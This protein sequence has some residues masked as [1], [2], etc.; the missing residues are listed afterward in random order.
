MKYSRFIAARY[1]TAERRHGQSASNKSEDRAEHRFVSTIVLIAA[2]GVALGVAALVVTLSILSGFEKTL[3]NNVLG[4]TSDVEISS[5]GNRPLPDFPGTTRFLTQRVPE[6]RSMVPFVEREAI[7]RS[8]HGVAGII[9]RGLPLSDTAALVRHR[10]VRGHDFASTTPDSLPPILISIGLAS[11]LHIDTGKTLAAIRMNERLRSR[12][13]ILANLRKFRVV[14]IY[15]TGMTQYDNSVAFT[16]LPAA[17]AFNGLSMT[18]VTGYDIRT[19]SI[20][21]ANPVTRKINRVLRYPYFARSVYDVYPTIFAWIDLQKKPIPIILGLIILVATFNVVS[22]LLLIVI[23]KTHSIGVLKTLGATMGGIAR[24][25]VTEG[26]TIAIFGTLIGDLI[27]FV[28]CT[29]EAHY[30]FFKLRAEIYFMSS[31]PVSIE[32]QHY[33]IVSGI[34]LALALAACLIPSRI[35]ARMQPLDALRF[36]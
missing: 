18:Q 23:E 21:D 22:T 1:L 16:T 27:A 20:A 3:T 8:P 2:A 7:L 12:E 29:L 34:A 11:D 13:D 26:M 28:L 19:A 17:Q 24:I 31:V 32:W 9:L 25:F 15:S 35:A 30:H 4:F 33:A 5:Y 6:I 14:G 10:I 36:A